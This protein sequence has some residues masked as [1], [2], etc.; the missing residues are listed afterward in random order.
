ML[1]TACLTFAPVGRASE[2]VG[3]PTTRPFATPPVTLSVISI[4]N[5]VL[6]ASLSFTFHRPQLSELLVGDVRNY[7]IESKFVFVANMPW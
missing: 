6:Q 5:A 3:L 7:S 4:K 2:V 1:K